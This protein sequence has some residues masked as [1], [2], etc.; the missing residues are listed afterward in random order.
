MCMS[1]VVRKDPNGIYQLEVYEDKLPEVT[2][3]EIAC[4][5]GSHFHY[6]ENEDGYVRFGVSDDEPFMGHRPGYMWSSRSGVFNTAFGK[7]CM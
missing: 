3:T 7:K 6:G 5:D 1:F 4:I 2:M